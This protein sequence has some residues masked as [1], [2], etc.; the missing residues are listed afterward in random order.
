M[1]V[2]VAEFS[3]SSRRFIIM[4]KPLQLSKSQ[5]LKG[6]QCPLSLW[7]ALYR[8]DLKPVLDPT[9]EALIKAGREVGDWA[10]KRFPGGIEVKAAFFDTPAGAAETKAHI[11]AGN[12]ILFEATAVHPGDGSHARADIFQKVPEADAWDLIEVKGTTGVDDYHIDDLAFQYRVFTAAGYRIN[13]CVIMHINNQYTRQGEID[14]QALFM[15]EDVTDAVMDRLA[16]E[17]R[18]VPELLALAEAQEPQ[19][20]IGARCGKPFDCNY[21]HHCWRGVPEYSI[22]DVLTV[23]K[24]EEMVESLGS[25]EVKSLPAKAHP[26]GLKKADVW[27]YLNGQIYIEPENIRQFLG[28]IQYPLYFLDYETVRH[29]VPLFDGARPFQQIP[30]QFSLHIEET[31]GAKLQH[32]SFLHQERSDPRP[33]FVERLLEVCGTAGTVIVYNQMFEEGVNEA[34]AAFIPAKSGE[35][36][37]INARMIDLL[38]P[39]KKRWIYHP[40]QNS[41]A[42]IKK[43]LPAFTKLTYD[44]M[45]ITNGDAASQLYLGFVKGGLAADITEQFWK[46]LHEYCHLDTYAMKI[47]LDELKRKNESGAT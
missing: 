22:F 20:R 30:F 41:S 14:P 2:C 10:K 45:G 42:S 31:P 29:P 12:N 3:A 5:Y 25:Y 19:V 9:R 18:A 37:A 11:D 16:D 21:V 8:R 34:L 26:T 38:D 23:K 44:G 15:T 24:A 27:S 35:L 13:R 6:S 43:V 33:G 36:L 1:P 47:L 46:D 39:F 40:S 32:H 28:N 7:Y 4:N 17:E